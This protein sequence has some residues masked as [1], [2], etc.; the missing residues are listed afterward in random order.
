MIDYADHHSGTVAVTPGRLNPY[1][2]GLELF[3]DIERRWNM[4]QFGPEWEAC[5]RMA[6]R[7][8]W[9]RKLGLGRERRST[10]CAAC[11]RDATFLDEFLTQDFCERQGLFVSKKNARTGKEEVESSPSKT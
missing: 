10:R 7:L 8:R 4:G 11:T 3:R 9:D 6:E 2:L 5:D 1:K